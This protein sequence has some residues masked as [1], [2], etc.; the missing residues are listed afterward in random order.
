MIY[1]YFFFAAS[2]ALSLFMSSCQSSVP[3][4]ETGMDE[5][6]IQPGNVRF[7]LWA[8]SAEAVELRLY[9]NG[10]TGE[11]YKTIDM[12][13]PAGDSLWQAD[14]SGDL[15]GKFYTFRVKREGNWMNETPGITAKAV[16][17]NGKRG[18]IVDMSKTNPDGWENDRRPPLDNYTDIVL[19]EMHYRDFSM[20]STSGI[21]NKGKFLAL[22]EEGTVSPQGEKTGIDHLKELGVTHVHLLP[23][24]D[25]GSIDETTL[26]QNQYNWGYDPLNYNAPEGSYSTD[27]YTPETR[28]REMKEMIQALHKNGI[29]V[30]MDVVYNHTH[31]IDQSNFTLTEPGYFYRHNPDG[32]YSDASACGNETA[33][34]KEEM[35]R[36]I[37]ESVKHWANEYHV[38]GFRFDLMGIHDTETMNAVSK[39]LKEIDPTIFV[40]G[41][42]W[43]AGPSPY[44]AN[45]RALKANASQM[46]GIA[47][48]ND[49]I[50]DGIKGSYK[51]GGSRG[52]ATGQPDLEESVK[53]GIV[54]ATQHPDI[55]YSKVNYSDAPYA[56]EP[57]QSINY[58]S[59]HDDLCLTDK[60]I[61]SN[62]GSSV[63]QLIRFD[64]LAQTIVFT[65]QGV[66]FI[67]N[68]EEI[69]RSKKGVH[70]SY[71]SPDSV[72]QINW[73]NKT[74]Y[75][76]LFNYY[77]Q[78]IQLRKNHPAFRMSTTAEIQKN[79]RFFQTGVNNVV[80]YTLNNHANGDTWG[81]IL[82][83]FNGNQTARQV[84]LPQGNWTVICRDGRIDEQGLGK[85][86]GGKTLIAPS[87]A[88]IM[89]Q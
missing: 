26:D 42:G 37:V 33:S 15:S 43:A 3:Q 73:E 52:F 51:D 38:D 47:V 39:A 20:D 1:S 6:T 45:K 44:P 22:T 70:N 17:V 12:K 48:F 35:R 64:K 49:D 27:P 24:Y 79:L 41:E 59:S 85:S 14:I 55:D 13:R 54:A 30:I 77:Q 60:L 29:R 5:L 19:Y 8:P 10:E 84:E 31:N 11:P 80:G 4:K 78:L 57:H 65:S 28:I 72:N 66:P 50:R 83:L 67:F 71:Q 87:S 81:E 25:F 53:F 69:F 36:F 62:P 40:Y 86:S 88:L 75:K 63:E 34:E 74:L 16:G 18:A 76:E 58:V 61:A 23:S 68:G 2:L 7:A 82:L 21:R 56:A 9:D 32:S 89:W 46:E